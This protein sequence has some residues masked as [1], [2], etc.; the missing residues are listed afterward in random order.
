MTFVSGRD[1]LATD[2]FIND[3]KA[4][5]ITAVKHLDA[6]GRAYIRFSFHCYNT[7]EEIAQ[8]EPIL[9]KLR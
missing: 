8:V 5:Q 6:A 1:S 2:T 7:I 9:Q 3:L 4:H